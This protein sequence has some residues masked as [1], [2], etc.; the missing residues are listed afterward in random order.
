MHYKGLDHI[1][2]SMKTK[3]DSKKVNV[4]EKYITKMITNKRQKEKGMKD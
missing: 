4:K 2:L 1:T 3:V